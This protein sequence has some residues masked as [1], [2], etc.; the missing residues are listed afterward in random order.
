M[1]YLGLEVRVWELHYIYIYTHDI[2]VCAFMFIHILR[3][4]SVLQH[5]H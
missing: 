2:C 1:I 5:S 3:Y 4:R